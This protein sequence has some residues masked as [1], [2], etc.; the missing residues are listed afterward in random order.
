MIVMTI[1]PMIA[2]MIYISLVIYN[3]NDGSYNGV[4]DDDDNNNMIITHL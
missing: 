4:K 1:I 3:N 2:K